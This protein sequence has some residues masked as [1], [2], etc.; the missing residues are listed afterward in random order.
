MPFPG[1]ID[2]GTPTQVFTHLS[3]AVTSLQVAIDLATER[4][5][6]PDETLLRL[7]DAGDE[8]CWVMQDMIDDNPKIDD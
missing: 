7:S 6:L 4:R 8:I 2:D 3:T 1:C 5:L